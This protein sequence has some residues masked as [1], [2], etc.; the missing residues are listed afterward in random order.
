MADQ[1]LFKTVLSN[2]H[3][4]LHRL[5]P[6]NK[7]SVYN[8]ELDR[9]HKLTLTSRPINR[10]FMI[11]AILLPACFLKAPIDSFTVFICFYNEFCHCF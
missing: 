6:K 11:T 9:A 8:L 2:S 1:S 5:L 4:V 3:H 10:V 7:T